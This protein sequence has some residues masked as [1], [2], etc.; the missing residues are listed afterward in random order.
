MNMKGR[1]VSGC[2]GTTLKLNRIC[3]LSPI[4]F[5]FS[6]YC[7]ELPQ[8]PAAPFAASVATLV[9]SLLAHVFGLNLPFSN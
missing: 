8:P 5:V 3:T 4:R 9:A 1:G 6:V 7:P 2:H